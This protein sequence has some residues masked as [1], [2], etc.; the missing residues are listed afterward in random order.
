MEELVQQIIARTGISAPQARQTIQLVIDYAHERL[1]GPAAAQIAG[2]LGSGPAVEQS[3][4]VRE[5]MDQLGGVRG[6]QD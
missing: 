5:H 2:A 1:P 3:P 4:L 6:R